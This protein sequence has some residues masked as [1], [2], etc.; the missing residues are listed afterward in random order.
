MHDLNKYV[1]EGFNQRILEKSA[2][3]ST[4]AARK[5]AINQL[6]SFLQAR[7][8]TPKN[9]FKTTVPKPKPKPVEVRS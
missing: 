1:W 7:G 3:V 5:K 4:P 6:S 2:A 9:P 8:V